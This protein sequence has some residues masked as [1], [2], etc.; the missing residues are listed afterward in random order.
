MRQQTELDI[1]SDVTT[2]VDIFGFRYMTDDGILM[3]NPQLH[4]CPFSCYNREN[5][6]NHST[7]EMVF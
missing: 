6:C 5:E 2:G 1:Q 4:S 3:V 7:D